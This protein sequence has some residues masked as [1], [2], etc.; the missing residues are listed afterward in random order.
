MTNIL[1]SSMCCS[2]RLAN[3]V[4][5]KTKQDPGFQIIKF[6]QLLLKG[7]NAQEGTMV[8]CLC[9]LRQKT[10]LFWHE[11]DEIE[12]SIKYHYLP[13]ISIMLIRQLFLYLCA[14]VYTIKWAISHKGDKA[15][16]C[17]IFASSV[18]M[19]T[20]DAAKLLG[21]KTCAII[22]DIP[23]QVVTT[24]NT[25]NPI[26]KLLLK[27]RTPIGKRNLHK[28][29]SYIFLTQAMNEVINK[30]GVPY[31]VMEGMVNNNEQLNNLNKQKPRIIF[32]AGALVEQFGV[33]AL[34]DAIM[35]SKHQDIEL[36]LYGD[37]KKSGFIEYIK[38]CSDKDK[39]I[40][41]KGIAKNE[42]I[43]RAEQ[44][45]T[46]LVNPRFTNQEFTKYSF[47]SKNMEYMVSNT[48][49]LTTR[50]PGM[51]KEYNDY[52]YLFDE[53]TAEGYAKKIDEI[54]D[55]K[56]ELLQTK[57]TEARQFVLENKSNIKQ[58]YRVVTLLRDV[59]KDAK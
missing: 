30:K 19:G 22:T 57:G 32:Y 42:D 10:K 7:I 31:I 34:V 16:I 33:K 38:K 55:L 44:A 23:G 1:Y 45:A 3:E 21:I 53:E 29:D 13:T 20:R 2:T 46:L 15:I 56:P 28:Y 11:K 27:I 36:H 43:V 50:L 47:P 58:A 48:P 26:L 8:T 49:L 4:L 35:L 52:V 25:K 9:G 54:L 5:E 18:S 17:D 24:I 59:I 51:P 6:T 12:D 41:Y 14:F 40:V 37:D 39:R